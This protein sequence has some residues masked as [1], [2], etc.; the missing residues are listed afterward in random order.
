MIIPDLNRLVY[1]HD[2]RDEEHEAAKRW[3]DD[4]LDGNETVG[5][6]WVVS[7]GYVRLATDP[8][9]TQN[10]LSPS[11]AIDV[12]EGWFKHPHVMPL[13]PGPAHMSYFRRIL[14]A[15]GS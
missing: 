2:E 4:L 10:P 9:I 15:S 7:A 8:R 11:R 1:A 3:W 12:V 5:I 6:P 14:N 13:N